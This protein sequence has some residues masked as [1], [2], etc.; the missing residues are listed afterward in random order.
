MCSKL[1][2]SISAILVLAACGGGAGGGSYASLINGSRALLL[3]IDDSVIASPGNV[4]TTGSATYEGFAVYVESDESFLVTDATATYRAIGDF[5]ADVNFATNEITTRYDSFYEQNNPAAFLDDNADAQPIDGSFEA[6]SNIF[7]LSSEVS[8]FGSLDGSL[9]KLSG[10]TQT[11]S[12]TFT[13]GSFFGVSGEFVVAI[14]DGLST[15]G[16]QAG[17]TGY[18]ER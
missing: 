17:I 12:D 7:R 3:E 5:E 11:Y 8:F 18:G 9:T 14:S 4:R 6:T 16:Q 1:P 15:T 13:L 10:E 2:F